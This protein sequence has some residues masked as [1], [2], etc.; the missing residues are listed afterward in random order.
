MTIDG[1]VR[2]ARYVSDAARLRSEIAPYEFDRR[3]LDNGGDISYAVDT[4]LVMLYRRPHLHGP[5]SQRGEGGYGVVFHD[6]PRETS[7]ALGAVLSRFVFYNL[8]GDATPLI[9][10]P[11]HDAEI[12]GMYEAVVR[13][14]TEEIAKVERQLRELPTILEELSGKESMEAQLEY[15]EKKTPDLLSY[16]YYSEDATVERS[17]FDQLLLDRRILRLVRALEGFDGHVSH[18]VRRAYAAPLTL[19]EQVLESTFRVAWER[20]LKPEKSPSRSGWRLRPDCTALARL[21]LI[22]HMLLRQREVSHRMVL[23]TG[24]EAM[25]RAA[26]KYEPIPGDRRTFSELYLRHPRAFLV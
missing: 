6:D 18:D 26:A 12:R 11:G 10:L 7:A 8:T 3:E 22:N 25:I 17:R 2:L 9:L 20:R 16:L 21:E 13:T 23:I 1:A 19:K 14:A 24:D 15:L 5:R 4:N